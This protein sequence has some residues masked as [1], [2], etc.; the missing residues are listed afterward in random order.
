MHE[1]ELAGAGLQRAGGAG[2]ERKGLGEHAGHELGH[3][4]GVFAGLQLPEAG[5]ATREVLVER[6]EARQLRE[7]DALVEDRVRLATEHLDRVAEVGERLGE[8]A[9]VHALA[10]HVGLA[11]VREV[12]DLERCVRI[13]SGRRH[14]I[15]A[16]GA[17][18]PPGNG[19]S[20]GVGSAQA[21]HQEM[22]MVRRSG[23]FG[24]TT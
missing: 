20:V 8:M 11:A 18:L 7:R 16:I 22:V 10:A 17:P 15:E 12:R 3:L 13:E 6:V 23:V 14:P 2:A 1:V 24:S 19:R 9:G 4:E 5:E 21:G